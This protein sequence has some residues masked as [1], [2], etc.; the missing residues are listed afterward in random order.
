MARASLEGLRL[1]YEDFLRQRELPQWPREDP[2][3]AKLIALRPATADNVANWARSTKSTASIKST[4]PEIAANGAL[5]LIVVA[6]SL[7]DRQIA[8]QEKA[9]VHEGGF[10]ERL[11][12]VRRRLRDS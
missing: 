1:D 9:F 12:G 11:Y 6:C 2:R 4:Y 10:T 5:T 7:L 3:R 8:A